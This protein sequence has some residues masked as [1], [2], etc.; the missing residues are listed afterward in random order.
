LPNDIS[1]CRAYDDSCISEDS[2][3]EGKD[4]ASL[5][6]IFFGVFLMGLGGSF[7]YVCGLPDSDDNST[8]DQ[9]PMAIA[10]I[11]AS[12][13]LGP[14]VGYALGPAC[15]K[16]YVKPWEEV[17]FDEDDPRWLGAWWLGFPVIAGFLLLATPWFALFPQRLSGTNTDAAKMAEEV[18]GDIAHI[19]SPSA[20][21]KETLA[22]YKRLLSIPIYVLNLLSLV[23]YLFG[24]IGWSQFQPKFLEFHFRKR[25][26][27]SGFLGK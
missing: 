25:A 14:A 5:W 13:L 18:A 7:Y 15:L 19:N 16:L 6:I 24:F 2:S 10:I 23:F 27:S 11:W 3:G 26:S 17:D 8:K 22:V 9:G 4:W 12:R 21:L 20:F 1:S